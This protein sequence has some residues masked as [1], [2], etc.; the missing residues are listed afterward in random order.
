VGV[1]VLASTYGF[2]Y[3]CMYVHACNSNASPHYSQGCGFSRDEIQILLMPVCIQN[4]IRS[5]LFV[6]LYIVHK[7]AYTKAEMGALGSR[8]WRFV[9]FVG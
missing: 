1:K 6:I 8:F 2:M 5:P 3:I 7:R 4:T 9:H